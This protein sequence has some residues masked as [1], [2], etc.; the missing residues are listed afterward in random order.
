MECVGNVEH[1]VGF[2][3]IYAFSAMHTFQCLC[4]CNTL[5]STYFSMYRSIQTADSRFLFV[6]HCNLA[7]VVDNGQIY[8]IIYVSYVHTKRP[9]IQFQ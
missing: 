5:A 4:V 6:S 2:A 9:S 8:N 1:V 3:H 7:V